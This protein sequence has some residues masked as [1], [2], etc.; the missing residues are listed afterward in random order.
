[1]AASPSGA[2][3]IRDFFDALTEQEGRFAARLA[4]DNL[5]LYLRAAINELDW[6]SYCLA[7]EPEPSF[8]QQ[9]EWYLLHLGVT[10]LIRLS[11]EGRA[12]FDVPAVMFRRRPGS[13]KL[14]LEMVA[15]LGMVEHGRRVAQMAMMGIGVVERTGPSEFLVTLPE[16]L[17]DEEYYERAVADHF[18]ALASDEFAKLLDTELARDTT[19]KVEQLVAKLVYPFMEHFIGYDSDPSIDTYF[20]GLA[21]HVLRMKTGYDAFNHAVRFGGVPFHMYMLGLTFLVSLAIR[22]ER[23]AEALVAKDPSIRLENV[24]TVS[25]EIAPFL[26]DMRAAI[27]FFGG[28]VEDFEE[29]TVEQAETIFRVLSVG[30]DNNGVLDRPGSALPLLVRTSENDCIRC[31]SAVLG[32]PMQFLLDSLRQHF[33][34]HY[35]ENQRGR[36]K[37]M[38]IAIRRI[39]DDVFCG[40]EYRD[41]VRLRLDRRTLT[42]IDVVVLEPATGAILL[43]QLKH[44]DIYG[45]DIHSR[46]ARGVRLK[47]QS[48]KW[49][50][51]VREW[52]D[53][54]ADADIASALR[55]PRNFPPPH[56][57][58]VLLARHFGYPVADLDRQPD[59]AF[60]NWNQFYNATLQAR[61]TPGQPTLADFVTL[62]QG[63]E[64]PGGPQ[65]HHAGPRSEWIINELSFTTR[66]EDASQSSVEAAAP[67]TSA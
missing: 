14:V 58:R 8:E 2:N 49:L 16:V 67:S 23:S 30:R 46:H 31:Q 26:N 6:Y 10:R 12:S 24:L 11:L 35:D 13:T 29:A 66:Q 50:A 42:D 4:E 55:L 64:S 59:F 63:G 25:A 22:H 9:E 15:G 17:P 52:V 36:E 3:A 62:L 54:S 47:Q 38:Q 60:A 28:L 32:N 5:G 7:R 1:M 20:F 39:L 53:R 57:Y 56:M 43:I 37:S 18:K 21:S 48:E 34:R 33:P 27:N 61:Q 65:H 44:Q 51:A 19:R 41:N 40:L 45:M